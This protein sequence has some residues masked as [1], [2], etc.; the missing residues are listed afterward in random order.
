MNVSPFF[1]RAL[2]AAAM[3]ILAWAPS[4][5]AGG[6]PE[7]IFLIVNPQGAQSQEIANHYIALRRIPPIN[8]MYLA[9]PPNAPLIKGV[10]FRDKILRPILAEIER[11]GL[12]DRIDLI[13]YS[14]EF[15]FQVDCST[16]IGLP[17][18]QGP[19]RPIASLTGATYLYQLIEAADKRLV[20]LNTNFYFAP[21]ASGV[22]TT[23]AFRAKDAW[24]PGG[25]RSDGAGMQYLMSVQLGNTLPMGNTA[26]EIV[27]YLKRAAAADGTRPDGVFYFMQ[28]DNVRS[29]V[30]QALYAPAAAELRTLGL[31][32][33][34]GQ[35]VVPS[36]AVNLNGLT[37]GSAI[38]KLRGSGSRLQPGA[39]VDNLTSAGAQMQRPSNP[40]PATQQTRVSEYLRL[41]AAGASGTVI[42]PFAI[43]QKFPAPALHVHYARGATMAEA[44][45]QSVEGPFQL[46][47]VG[48]PLCQPW[49][50]I[51]QVAVDGVAEGQLVSKTIPLTPT[52]VLA[53]GAGVSRFDLY[54]DGKLRGS[55]PEGG[56][57]SLDTTTLGDGYH[58]LRVVAV[59]NTVIETQGRWIGGVTVKNGTNAVSISAANGSRVSGPLL[60]LN[61]TSTVE[62]PIAV[63]HNGREVGR[64]AGKQGTIPILTEKLGKG[65]VTLTAR[66]AGTPPLLSRPLEL[67]VQ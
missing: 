20:E 33:E 26:A 47:I 43:P 52:A 49:A 14:A 54:V 9:A 56:A 1:P 2:V 46:L 21:I 62:G 58:E 25:V 10:D 35:G 55:S 37:T 31:K 17:N 6:G 57:L 5:V 39:L 16:L 36:S 8:V 40:N 34:I 64:I 51:P 22:T 48:D 45:Y 63:F 3:A 7:N 24:L 30:R 15:P 66:T 61:A 13:A 11:R 32:A 38:V 50:D 41:G 65:P 19:Q 59:A 60:S 44:F 67:V 27:T 18:T 53:G 4:A 12:R 28:N 29:Q 42:E 23:Q